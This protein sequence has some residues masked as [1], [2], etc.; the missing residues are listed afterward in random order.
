KENDNLIVERAINLSLI[1]IVIGSF[2]HNFRVP[3]AGHILSLNQGAFLCRIS[4]KSENRI[5]A[6]QSSYEV[7]VVVA[8]MKSLSP[9]DKKIGPML[10]I[11]MQGFLFSFATFIF[12]K[13]TI[14]QMFS[15]I[16]LSIWA[17]LQPLITYFLIFGWSLVGAFKFY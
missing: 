15:M 5:T 11:S 8:M 14:G 12:G 10:S 4:T 2:L 6:A 13:N 3:F 1:E 9:S 17:F 7:S 16:F